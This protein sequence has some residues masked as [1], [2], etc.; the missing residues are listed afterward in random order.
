MSQV[1]DE[2]EKQELEQ[3]NAV[4]QSMTS[5]DGLPS[6]DS[7]SSS[8]SEDD[9]DDGDEGILDLRAA[10]IPVCS[11]AGEVKISPECAQ[12]PPGVRDV[13]AKDE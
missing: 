8:S 13:D 12:T 10:D 7:S 11:P 3:L 1:E 4:S 2:L 5:E 6:D 9:E